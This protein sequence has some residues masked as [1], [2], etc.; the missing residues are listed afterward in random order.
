M[1]CLRTRF[2][3][4]AR[5]RCVCLLSGGLFR[6]IAATDDPGPGLI[7]AGQDR[8]DE[9]A[10]KEYSPPTRPSLPDA[11]EIGQTGRIVGR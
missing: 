5:A 1:L 10:A 3:A 7:N 9:I 11:A 2:R 8:D 6:R 4:G